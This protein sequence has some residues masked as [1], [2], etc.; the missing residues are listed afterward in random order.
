MYGDSGTGKSL[1]VEKCLSLE[2]YAAATANCVESYSLKLIYEGVINQLTKHR[3]S[4]ENGFQPYAKCNNVLEFVLELRK[5]S[6]K[7]GIGKKDD[8]SIIIVLDKCEK[9]RGLNKNLI[10]ALVKLREL[11]GLKLC[12]VFVSTLPWTHFFTHDYVTQPI[13]IFLQ[14][15]DQKQ[16]HQILARDKPDGVSAPFYENFLN[17]FLSVFYNACHDLRELQYQVKL[18]FTNY[19]EPI[20]KGELKETDAGQLWKRSQPFFKKA[21]RSLYLKVDS[22]MELSEVENI[23]SMTTQALVMEL[24]YYSKYVLIGS[25]IASYNPASEDKR[26]F[27]KHSG[28]QRKSG[29]PKSERAKHHLLGPKPFGLQR[30]FSIVSAILNDEKFTLNADLFV[31][32]SY[33]S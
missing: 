20:A 19:Y 32:V 30:L 7:T 13:S 26:L 9:L 33:W 5:L 24:P 16:L 15:Y 11:S 25:Y 1:L 22:G 3:M 2:D 28:K 8:R 21:L 10:P 18:S 27:V 6:E 12:V 31:E 17:L 14:Q 29:K 4:S 23:T